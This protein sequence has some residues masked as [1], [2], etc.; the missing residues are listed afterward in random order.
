MRRFPGLDRK[1]PVM[2]DLNYLLRDAGNTSDRSAYFLQPVVLQPVLE[3]V[4][5]SELVVV[6][7]ELVEV[8]VV[9]D[10]GAV[11]VVVVVVVSL[12]ESSTCAEASVEVKETAAIR[13]TANW[14]FLKFRIAF[15]PGG[16]TE[17][18]LTRAEAK[19]GFV[20]GASSPPH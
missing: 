12:V 2:G 16:Q 17:P 11:V 10:E 1:V 4:V 19:R 7:P 5:V 13:A 15:P 3:L 9:V 18:R 20:K 8:V 6:V 14:A